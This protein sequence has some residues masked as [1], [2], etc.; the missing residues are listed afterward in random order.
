M[1]LHENSRGAAKNLAFISSMGNTSMSKLMGFTG[2]WLKINFGVSRDP[3]NFTQA[4][5]QQARQVGKDP[6]AIKQN[7][8]DCWAVSDT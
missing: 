8:Q 4:Q 5:W 1:I 3:K 2:L 7:L 6:K